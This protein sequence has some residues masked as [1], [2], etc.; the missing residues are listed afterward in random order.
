MERFHVSLTFPHQKAP[1]VGRVPPRP[2]SLVKDLQLCC[3]W[4]FPPQEGISW[5][6]WQRLMKGCLAAG[7]PIWGAGFREAMVMTAPRPIPPAPPPLY[8][9]GDQGPEGRAVAG[10]PVSEADSA[11]M[12]RP[13]MGLVLSRAGGDQSQ[14][15]CPP[16]PQGRALPLSPQ[17]PEASVATPDGSWVLPDPEGT[18]PNI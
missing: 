18:S 5:F 6:P 16:C 12:L 8:I 4:V 11:A 9:W 2:L 14:P 17:P 15:P 10:P 7:A 3:H 1:L 13:L